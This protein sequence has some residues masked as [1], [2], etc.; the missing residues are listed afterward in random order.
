[1]KQPHTVKV[2]PFV[3]RANVPSFAGGAGAQTRRLADI[4][5]T[6]WAEAGH[7]VSVISTMNRQDSTAYDPTHIIVSD[8]VGGLPPRKPRATKSRS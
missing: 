5:R 4:I 7:E 1:M 8:L 6:R 3:A 2:P